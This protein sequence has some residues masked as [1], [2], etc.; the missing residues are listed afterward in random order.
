VFRRKEQNS[1]GRKETLL[2]IF[3]HYYYY[4]NLILISSL[5]NAEIQHEHPIPIRPLQYHADLDKVC[6]SDT[7]DIIIC[8]RDLAPE[9]KLCADLH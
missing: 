9:T 2:H 8:V 3:L 5:A 4:M 6:N 7:S 1:T